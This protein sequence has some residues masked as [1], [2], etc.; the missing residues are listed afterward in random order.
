MHLSMFS[1]SGGGGGGDTLGIRPTKQSLL[2]GIEQ[3]TSIGILEEFMCNFTEVNSAT[4]PPLVENIDSCI[5][6]A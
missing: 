6:L 2:Q 3:N 1:P 4:Y 5:D